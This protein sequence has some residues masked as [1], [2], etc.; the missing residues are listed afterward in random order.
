MPCALPWEALFQTITGNIQ[1]R[2]IDD[3]VHCDVGWE[4]F[5]TDFG[6]SVFGTFETCRPALMMSVHWGRPEV[7]V[8]GSKRR[9]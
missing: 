8:A 4:P 7:I 6:M 3:P 9:F 1:I 2:W 5:A